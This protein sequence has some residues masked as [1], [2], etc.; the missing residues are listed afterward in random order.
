MVL[1]AGLT[2]DFVGLYQINAV[3]PDTAPVGLDVPLVIRA[4]A[5]ASVPVAIA[6]SPRPAP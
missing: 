3:V 6:V 1:F 4:G 5:R 2:P